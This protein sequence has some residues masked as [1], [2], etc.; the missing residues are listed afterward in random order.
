MVY[1]PGEPQEHFIGD[2]FGD[3]DLADWY[4][5]QSECADKLQ[6]LVETSADTRLLEL[7]IVCWEAGKFAVDFIGCNGVASYSFMTLNIECV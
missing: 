6:K 5:E 2:E 1:T 3:L 4:N 7:L